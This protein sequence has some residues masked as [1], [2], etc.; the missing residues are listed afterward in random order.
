M[1]K[2]MKVFLAIAILPGSALFAGAALHATDSVTPASP[3]LTIYPCGRAMAAD[4]MKGYPQRD[5]SSNSAENIRWSEPE[6]TFLAGTLETVFN[7]LCEEKQTT[8]QALKGFHTIQMIDNENANVIGIFAASEGSHSGWSS[9][10]LYV[11][12]PLQDIFEKE[13][14]RVEMRRSILCAFNPQSELLTDPTICLPD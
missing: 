7:R 4:F 14:L 8:D 12:V 3:Q 5:S 13:A 9:E 10:T 2:G 1:F 11:E 6:K